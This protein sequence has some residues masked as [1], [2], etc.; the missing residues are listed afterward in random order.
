M[1]FPL[2]ERVLGWPTRL[3][4]GTVDFSIYLELKAGRKSL[5]RSQDVAL[6][7]HGP[8]RVGGRLARAV[9]RGEGSQAEERV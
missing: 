2:R 6:R 1:R 9:G 3:L 5:C 8:L 4:R 7:R